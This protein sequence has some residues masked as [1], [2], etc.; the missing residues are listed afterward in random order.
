M[1]EHGEADLD[2]QS[3]PVERWITQAI[4]AAPPPDGVALRSAACQGL[5]VR[6]NSSRLDRILVN[7]LT[8][9]YRYGGGSVSLT[10]HRR[11]RLR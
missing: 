5:V 11:R 10:A 9:A 2:A 6:G 8:N 7:L 4:E 1:I 3:V